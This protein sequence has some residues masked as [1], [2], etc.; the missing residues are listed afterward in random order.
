MQIETP[1]PINQTEDSATES[2][3]EEDW[4]QL[5]QG[6]L[7]QLKRDQ[8]QREKEAFRKSPIG[9]PQASTSTSARSYKRE[10]RSS[11]SNSRVFF[12][13]CKI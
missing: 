2:E 13:W 11:V 3:T 8:A 9:S 6:M 7:K 1:L 12:C 10:S 4:L 5:Q